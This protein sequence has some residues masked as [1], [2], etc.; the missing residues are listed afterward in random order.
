MNLYIRTADLLS[1][2]LM[3]VSDKNK[4]TVFIATR[5]KNNPFL[6]QL[7]NRLNEKVAE[8]KL[9]NSFLKIFSIEVGGQEVATIN[10]IPMIDV[11]Y[12]HIGKLNWRIVGNI[13]MSDY[14]AKY[15]HE[16]IMEV[17][18]IILSLGQPGLQLKFQNIDDS[19][20]GTLIAIFLNKYVKMPGKPL[21]DSR[22][23]FQGKG[24]L[25]YLSFKNKC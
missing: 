6:I 23:S 17:S 10:T 18:P 15:K 2:N 5:D 4:E 24:K 14:H 1:G 9:K 7:F 11:K 13:P 19:E 3:V 20:V 25:S 8:I 12:V 22:N 21:D 16:V